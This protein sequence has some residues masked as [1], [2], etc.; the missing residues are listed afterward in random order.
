[1]DGCTALVKRMPPHLKKVHKLPP[2]SV[3][4][5]AALSRVRRLVGDSHRRPYDEK[6]SSPGKD[7]G[8][9]SVRVEALE[10]SEDERE[11][12]RRS[13]HRHVKSLDDSESESETS[14]HRS[15][16]TRVVEIE[17]SEAPLKVLKNCLKM[18]LLNLKPGFDQPTEVSL[19]RKPANSMEIKFP[20]F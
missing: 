16:Y 12:R 11:V 7:K 13:S 3:E 5:K 17:D 9:S 10:E 4:F 18:L 1:M 20:S 6:R 2:D 14:E 8:E 15:I 19:M